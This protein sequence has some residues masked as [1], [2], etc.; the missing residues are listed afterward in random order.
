M[1]GAAA[2]LVDVAMDG[3]A[4]PLCFPALRAAGFF[5]FFV[6]PL[7]NSVLSLAEPPARP[8]A[9]PA[10]A[11]LTGRGGAG[12]KNLG[13]QTVRETVTSLRERSEGGGAE[14]LQLCL[15]G[16]LRLS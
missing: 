9:G 4:G 15:A 5:S 6:P 14:G 10:G 16:L 7:A 8:P 1:A 12:A 2:L 13:V 11:K 3:T